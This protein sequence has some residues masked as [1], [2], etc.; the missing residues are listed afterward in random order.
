MVLYY[1]QVVKTLL[2]HGSD[3]HQANDK[4]LTP[5]GSC[6]DP[7]IL[8]LLNEAAGVEEGT[9]VERVEGRGEETGGTGGEN[10]SGPEEEGD[11]DVFESKSVNDQDTS[12]A[13]KSWNSKST[14]QEGERENH[15]CEQDPIPSEM[16]T[17]KKQL[18]I[19]FTTKETSLEEHSSTA[20]DGAD[21][22]TTLTKL[23]GKATP[24]F[25]DISSSESESELPEIKLTRN[26][27]RESPV[28]IESEDKGKGENEEGEMETSS[29]EP[30]EEKE[31]ES[32]STKEE[33][34]VKIY[35]DQRLDES[36][37]QGLSRIVCLGKSFY[38]YVE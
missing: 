25:S 28:T 35:Q 3:P 19:E 33:A 4:G 30:A 17:V 27:K 31:E 18:N 22:G 2:E 6:K 23:I 12:V 7:T 9:G 24:F 29:L 21:S 5:A 36:G 15:P 14:Q 16:S 37:E 11:E 8:K 20:E 34:K 13:C 26:L 32:P 38:M 1:V 10:P